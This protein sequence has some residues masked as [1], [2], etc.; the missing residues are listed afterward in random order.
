MDKYNFF[1]IINMVTAAVLT[2]LTFLLFDYSVCIE[3]L[4]LFVGESDST[5]KIITA[6][7]FTIKIIIFAFI[8]VISLYINFILRRLQNKRKL[9]SDKEIVKFIADYKG[10]NKITMFGFSL[11]FAESLRLY[12]SNHKMGDVDVVLYLPTEDFIIQKIEE[13]IPKESRLS[14]LRGRIH[15]WEELGN[16]NMIKSLTIKR[17]NILPV[18]NGTIINDEKCFLFTYNWSIEGDKVRFTKLPREER[19]KILISKNEREIWK[20]LMANICCYEELSM[21]TNI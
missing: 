1:K 3:K 8:L 4:L 20:Y 17:F 6:M 2:V 18:A 12:L 16:N 7:D 19:L 21:R 13:G 10:L 11:S 14:Q 15:E 5:E 9:Y